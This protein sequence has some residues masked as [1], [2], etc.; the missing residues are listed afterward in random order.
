MRTGSLVRRCLARRACSRGGTSRQSR[1]VPSR[2]VCTLRAAWSHW[3][4]GHWRCFDIFCPLD[5]SNTPFWCAGKAELFCDCLKLLFKYLRVLPFI[6]E[7]KL[8]LLISAKNLP[9]KFYWSVFTGQVFFRMI[10]SQ[11]WR[12]PGQFLRA[13]RVWQLIMDSNSAFWYLMWPS[14]LSFCKS[15]WSIRMGQLQD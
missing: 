9:T 5:Y 3:L 2:G 12:S 15:R 10:K 1:G 14:A 4:W 7:R 6:F 11:A 8:H 13:G